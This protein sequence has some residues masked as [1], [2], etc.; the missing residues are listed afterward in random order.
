[1]DF[2]MKFRVR[3]LGIEA[4]GKFVA[5]LNEKD[6]LELGVHSQDTVSIRKNGKECTAMVDTSKEVIPKGEIGINYDI[7]K[8]LGISFGE[9]IVVPEEPPASRKFIRKKIKGENLT[10]SEIK[11]IIKDV[12]EFNLTETEISAFVTSLEIRGVTLEEAYAMSMAMVE[13]GKTLRIPKNGPI[14]DKH[15]IGGVPGNKTSL[16]IVPIIAAGG[17]RI[18]KTSSRAIT[19]PAGTADRMEVLAPVSLSM[20]EVKKVVQKT[21]GCITWGGALDLSPADD[22]FIKSEYPLSIDPMLLPS[23]MSKKKSVGA[24]HLVIDIPTGDGAKLETIEESRALGEN[25]VELGK[26]MGINVRCLISFASQPVG[27]CIGPALE[28]YEALNAYSNPASAT[29]L[30][31]KAM[32]MCNTLF[33]MAGK[34]EAAWELLKSGKAERKFREIIGEQGGNSKIKG[35]EICLGER[36]VSVKSSCSGKVLFIRNKQLSSIARLLGAPKDKGAGIYLDRKLGEAVKKGD[37][38]LT[39]YA[40][41]AYKMERAL[42]ALESLEPSVVSESFENKML[43]D[44]VPKNSRENYFILER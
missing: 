41:K 39:L 11:Q 6:L 29:D 36:K 13:A 8:F 10:H 28:A 9:V 37:P 4:G 22:I 34:K 12:S 38:L 31:N 1:M 18:P 42:K 25:F 3:P 15:S 23:V 24:K 30:V 19:S 21:G 44:T 16:L 2:E 33:V 32:N 40:E 5:V 43:L 7:E 17:L 35:S 27:R 20:S 14:V 26:R